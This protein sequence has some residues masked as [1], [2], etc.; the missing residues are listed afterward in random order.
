M[1]VCGKA[2]TT[3]VGMVQFNIV[4]E[5][6]NELGRYRAA[7]AAKKTIDKKT[8]WNKKHSLLDALAALYLPLK[9]IDS[10]FWIHTKPCQPWSSLL[11]QAQC[12]TPSWA[13][14]AAHNYAHIAAH[15]DA[16]KMTCTMPLNFL[17]CRA[18][19]GIIWTHAPTFHNCSLSNF[20]TYSP[21]LPTWP[22]YLTYLPTKDKSHRFQQSRMLHRHFFIGGNLEFSTHVPFAWKAPV[23][24]LR[25]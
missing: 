11:C 18:G 22:S 10:L 9:V 7:R 5:W 23:T 15:N 3:K 14:N 4:N 25:R 2:K 12:R 19:N 24:I 20:L 17:N 13:Y 16:H 1:M 6:M 21:D 8:K